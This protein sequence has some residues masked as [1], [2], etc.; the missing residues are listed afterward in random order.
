[1]TLVV[2]NEADIGTTFPAAFITCKLLGQL[3]TLDTCPFH[4]MFLEDPLTSITN[5]SFPFRIIYMVSC[6]RVFFKQALEHS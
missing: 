5:S 1:M 6:K 2:A 3:I 4:C